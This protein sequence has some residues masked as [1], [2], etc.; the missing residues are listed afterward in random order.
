M[1]VALDNNVT[2]VLDAGAALRDVTR[3]FTQLQQRNFA[4]CD[5]QSATQWAVVTTLAHSGDQ[6][7][8]GP[9]PGGLTLSALTLTLNLDKAWL[10]R[11]IDD[12]VS[13]GLIDKGPHPTD[14]RALSVCLTDAG[15]TAA[16]QLDTQLSAQAER[17]LARLPGR[18]RAQARQL[19]GALAGA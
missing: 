10:S 11:N 9:I 7:P 3:L 1:T 15:R 8:S 18:D 13:Q 4:C 6:T 14:R 2:A 5:V 12:L 16:A 19:L 17:V